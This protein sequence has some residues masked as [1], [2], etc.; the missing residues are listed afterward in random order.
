MSNNKESG[1]RK[2]EKL[3]DVNVIQHDRDEFSKLNAISKLR[4]S[5]KRGRELED[6]LFDIYSNQLQKQ[7]EQ[8]EHQ[9]FLGL[10]ASKK[11]LYEEYLVRTSD[12]EKNITKKLNEMLRDNISSLS[13]D[14]EKLFDICDD[15]SAK[16]E[17]H[18]G[19]SIRYKKLQNSIKDME[20]KGVN[21]FE[22]RAQVLH[23]KHEQLF[24]K[25]VELFKEQSEVTMHDE[26]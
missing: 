24:K 10:D 5:F 23:E 9:L 11:K 19:N 1:L 3:Y 12:I 13:D 20:L 16:S 14:L 21:S 25:T 8:L 26:I 22:L 18:K 4:Q 17:R 15:L 7:K 2:A 6:H